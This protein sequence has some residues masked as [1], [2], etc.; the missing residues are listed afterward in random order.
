[1]P[2]D[3][4]ALEITFI[5]HE[6]S[7]CFLKG[8]VFIERQSKYASSRIITTS[9]IDALINV[10]LLKRLDKGIIASAYTVICKGIENKDNER[11]RLI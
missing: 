5:M 3:P 9:A 7:K 6:N 8:N 10:S 4:A 2:N 11:M 1:M